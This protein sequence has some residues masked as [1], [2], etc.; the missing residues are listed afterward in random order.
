MEIFYDME[1]FQ[2]MECLVL[3]RVEIPVE[4]QDM[5]ILQ[6][7]DI[8]NPIMGLWFDL[9]FQ[10]QFMVG[11]SVQTCSFKSQRNFQKGKNYVLV[12]HAVVQ[13]HATG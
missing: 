7:I 2:D 13:Y 5:D 9:I 4:I 8:F 6:D 10:Y 3:N 12:P 1:N 11:L